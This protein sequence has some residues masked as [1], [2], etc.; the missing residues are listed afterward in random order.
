VKD[1]K[2]FKVGDKI[3]NFGQVFRIFKSKKK[4]ISKDKEEKIIF[5]RPYFKNRKNRTLIC[6][7]PVNNLDKTNIRRPISK[8]ELRLLLKKLSRKSGVKEPI[9]LAQA[10]GVLGLNDIYKTAQVLKSLWVEKND[11]SANFSESRKNLFKLL[12][13]QLV[14]EVAFVGRISLIQARKKIKV[15]LEKGVK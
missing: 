8:K 3:V 6:S 7:I 1:K 13:K 11:E 10:R 15:A 4:K 14:E 9:N 12:M 2:S 5:F